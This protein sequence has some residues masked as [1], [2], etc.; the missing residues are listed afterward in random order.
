MYQ[1]DADKLF[2]ARDALR[3]ECRSLRRQ[4]DALEQDPERVL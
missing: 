3:R 4:N 2:D 1:V